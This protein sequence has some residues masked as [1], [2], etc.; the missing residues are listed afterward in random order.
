[1][2]CILAS[3]KN[4]PHFVLAVDPRCLGTACC[5]GGGMLEEVGAEFL[6]PPGTRGT[7]AL[8]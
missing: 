4:K 8:A 5:A 3:L 1:M 7:Q 6:P 2:C